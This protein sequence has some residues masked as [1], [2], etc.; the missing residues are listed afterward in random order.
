MVLIGS[1]LRPSVKAIR[2]SK[3]PYDRQGKNKQSKLAAVF[4]SYAYLEVAHSLSQP[5]AVPF[6]AARFSDAPFPPWIQYKIRRRLIGEKFI[7]INEILQALPDFLIPLV[8]VGILS[9]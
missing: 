9:I 7:E 8:C 1:N 4:F 5:A 3:L 6:P 2:I